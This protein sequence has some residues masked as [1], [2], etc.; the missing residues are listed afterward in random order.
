MRE[1]QG[2]HSFL[3]AELKGHFL[4]KPLAATSCQKES[5]LSLLSEPLVVAP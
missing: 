3:E 5:P 2:F 4:G 1:S